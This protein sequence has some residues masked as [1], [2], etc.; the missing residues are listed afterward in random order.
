MG[1]KKIISKEKLHESITAIDPTKYESNYYEDPTGKIHD[2]RIEANV[3]HKGEGTGHYVRGID[4]DKYQD[5]MLN[6][7]ISKD[8]SAMDYLR[9]AGDIAASPITSTYGVLK[10]ATGFTGSTIYHAFNEVRKHFKYGDTNGGLAGDENTGNINAGAERTDISGYGTDGFGS[11]AKGAQDGSGLTALE[12]HAPWKTGEFNL[13]G[14]SLEQFLNSVGLTYDRL[15]SRLL[16][17]NAFNKNFNLNSN[18]MVSFGRMYAFFTRPDLFLFM[19]DGSINPTIKTN[20]P[21]LYAKIVGNRLVAEALQSIFDHEPVTVGGKGFL[22]LLTNMCFSISGIDLTLSEKEAPQNVKGLNVKYGGDFLDS[23]KETTLDL[24]FLDNRYR[25]VQT[26][27]EI[28]TEYIEGVS[29]GKIYKK[30]YY[31]DANIIDYAVSIYIIAVDETN[32]IIYSIGYVGCY[33]KTVATTLT[34]YKRESL[35][36]QDIMGP[37]PYTWQVSHVLRPNSHTTIERFNYAAG[38]ERIAETYNQGVKH[39]TDYVRMFKASLRKYRANNGGVDYSKPVSEHYIMHQSISAFGLDINR[40]NAAVDDPELE[41]FENQLSITEYFPQFTGITM[42]MDSGG[43]Y[44]YNLIFYSTKKYLE[45]DLAPNNQAKSFRTL[46]DYDK[47]TVTNP[48]GQQLN[49]MDITFVYAMRKVGLLNRGSGARV[50]YS[51]VETGNLFDSDTTSVNGSHGIAS[52]AGAGKA[53]A[54]PAHT[55]K[56]GVTAP[57]GQSVPKPTVA[58]KRTKKTTRA[59]K[60]KRRAKKPKTYSVVH[61]DYGGYT[62]GGSYGNSTKNGWGKKP[63][64]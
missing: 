37:Y 33:P 4:Y 49:L 28:W 34:N 3:K 30:K 32:N 2:G 53:K 23:L 21:S 63:H 43:V 60:S 52:G 17:V 39:G 18:D 48:D 11:Y 27:M 29:Q 5:A 54:G 62:I 58:K 45:S 8:K 56:A 46:I 61:P 35:T 25:D 41:N 59:V 24:Q 36:G 14:Y 16:N 22:N 6:K 19:K 1:K 55:A 13:A 44:H 50:D 31:R 9:K 38:F 40:Y 7:N 12:S 26:M 51:D 57:K 10:N 64:S 20:C 15:Q 42:S 47:R